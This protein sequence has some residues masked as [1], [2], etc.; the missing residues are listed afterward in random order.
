MAHFSQSGKYMDD[1]NLPKSDCVID[2][3]T[4]PSKR[5]TYSI[6]LFTEPG[7]KKNHHWRVTVFNW[8]TSDHSALTCG[9]GQ[10]GDR[11]TRGPAY[12]A[13]VAAPSRSAVQY[14][15]L[16]VPQQLMVQQ[17]AR[18]VARVSVVL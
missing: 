2:S 7:I 8:F 5:H 17:S 12:E 15:A 6:S 14:A 10:P 9:M 3:F 18:D 4:Q 11:I 13:L 1:A 16:L